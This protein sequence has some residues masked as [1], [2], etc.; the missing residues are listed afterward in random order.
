MVY[1]KAQGASKARPDD[2]VNQ[3]Q[4][5]RCLLAVSASQAGEGKHPAVPL[6]AIAIGVGD[7]G[8][9]PVLLDGGHLGEVL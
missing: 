1:F 2:Q 3:F 5:S 6:R 8:Q 9:V 7:V 4:G